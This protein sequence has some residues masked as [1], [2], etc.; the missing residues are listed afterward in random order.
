[1]TPNELN[2][3]VRQL[4]RRW[5]YHIATG[6]YEL[7]ERETK[8]YEHNEREM[9]R[10]LDRLFGADNGFEYMTK[11]SLMMILA[12]NQSLRIIPLHHLAS[13]INTVKLFKS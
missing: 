5:N 13:G 11:R 9:K 6:H 2:R 4:F 8:N 12:M 7:N 1:M 10:E 3:D